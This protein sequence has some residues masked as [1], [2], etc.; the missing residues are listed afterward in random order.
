MKERTILKGVMSLTIIVEIIMM[1]WV[2][3]VIGEERLTVQFIRLIFQLVLMLL[4]LKQKSNIALWI[5][6]GF[7]V[8][9]GLMNWAAINSGIVGQILSVYHFVIAGIICFYDDI[10]KKLLS[11]KV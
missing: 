11:E 4:I 6:V 2:Y 3:N 10:E 5:L 8:F 1:I 7:H 9:S